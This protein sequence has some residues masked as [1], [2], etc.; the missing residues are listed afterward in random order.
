[1]RGGRAITAGVPDYA[2][3]DF[4]PLPPSAA[5]GLLDGL[6]PPA[7]ADRV[8]EPQDAAGQRALEA[9]VQ[10]RPSSFVFLRSTVPLLFLLV[11][12]G[13]RRLQRTSTMHA[14]YAY[15]FMEARLL[16]G[17]MILSQR[18]PESHPDIHIAFC[19]VP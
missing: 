10:F 13:Y 5:D 19:R 17:T 15:T 8:L 4:A 18:A 7:P 2:Q 14:E 6:V 16:E 11:G 9:Q 3:L 1:V 12:S